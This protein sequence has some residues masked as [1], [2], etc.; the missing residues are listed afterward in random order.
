[1]QNTRERDL[2]GPS[3]KRQFSIGLL[4]NTPCKNPKDTHINPRYLEI[5]MPFFSLN[6]KLISMQ[7][8]IPT[9]LSETE[10]TLPMLRNNRTAHHFTPWF[11]P[12]PSVS[13]TKKA[14]IPGVP[15]FSVDIHWT[16]LKRIPPRCVSWL[17]LSTPGCV[18]LAVNEALNL[19]LGNSE[20]QKG[21]P[22]VGFPASFPSHPN[23]PGRERKGSPG[24]LRAAPESHPR[25]LEPCPAGA[26][27]EQRSHVRTG[28]RRVPGRSSDRRSAARRRP[29]SHP[30][31]PAGTRAALGCRPSSRR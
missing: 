2:L 10:G 25:R 27:Q 20:K 30:D 19:E 6:T 29:P 1:M 13:H 21:R 9:F 31:A 23:H 5:Q 16:E 8:H 18:R 4:E 3:C 15:K 11:P 7:E 14:T 26:I 12:F 17:L 22:A 24:A 28:T